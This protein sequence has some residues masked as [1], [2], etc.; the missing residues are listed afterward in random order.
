MAVKE[1]GTVPGPVGHSALRDM[2]RAHVLGVICRDGPLSR[3]D[4]V[5][6]TRLAKPTVT[7]IVQDL[8]SAEVVRERGTR[9]ARGGSGRP[10]VLLEFDPRR[11]LVVGCH[12]GNTRTT[13]MVADL[14]GTPL[15]VRHRATAARSVHRVLDGLVE[16]VIAALAAAGE[17]Q[18][19]CAAGVSIPGEVDSTNGTCLHAFNFGWH[20]IPVADLLAQR[21]G[22]PVSAHPDAKA[23]L[24]AEVAEGAARDAM[25][26]ALL[27]EDQGIGM[28]L[29][30]GGAMVHGTKGIAGEIG[31]CHVPGATEECN[32]G[33][34]GCLETVAS[35]PALALAT[36]K[37]LGDQA[38]ALLP[39]RPR[40]ADLARLGMPDVDGLLAHA[41][42][43]VGIAASWLINL[44]NPQVLILGGGFPDAGESFLNAFSAAMSAQ[45]L[46]EASECVTVRASSIPEGAEVRGAVLAALEL[47]ARL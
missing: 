12:V 7:A 10:A 25:D 31:H 21:L 5:H 6:R 2:N 14:N 36:R 9:P 27:F 33:K 47:A 18:P 17:S 43:E 30:S 13:A 23:A 19:L 26:V 8:L 16:L 32:C 44:M 42:H 40:L 20:G 28:A 1:S 35:A 4:L 15:A 46:S 29:I 11:R 41:G 37:L 22:V 34:A 45:A 24:R 38:D 39:H 3:S